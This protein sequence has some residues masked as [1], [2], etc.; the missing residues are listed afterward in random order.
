M[1]NTLPPLASNDLFGLQINSVIASDT[2]IEKSAMLQVI[3]TNKS[4]DSLRS[5]VSADRT[6]NVYADCEPTIS[7][8][9]G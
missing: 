7:I 5:Q 1:R 4:N 8:W 3:A 6:R 2:V 9:M